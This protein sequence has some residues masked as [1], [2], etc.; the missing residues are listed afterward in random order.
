MLSVAEALAEIVRE[1]HPFQPE[2]IALSDAYGLTL[3]SP[4]VSDIDSPPFDKS[5]MD[6]FAV[7]AA[8]VV[9]GKAELQ[10]VEE[11]MAGQ[12]PTRTV[13][14][15]QATQ[16]MTGA[17]I[18]DGVDAVVRVEDSVYDPDTRIVRLATTAVQPGKNMITRGTNMHAGDEV[19]SAGRM[20]RPQELACLAELGCAQVSVRRRPRV[21]VLAT[22]DELVSVAE[23]PAAGQIRNSNETM[24]LAQIRRAGGEPIPLDIARD[25]RDDLRAKI[26][27]SLE[28]D[29]L[30]LSGGVSAGKL[31]LVPAVLEEAGVRQ[32]FHKV[33]VKPGKPLW[34]G[35]RK[36][37]ESQ[38]ANA[39][40]SGC[41]VFGLPGN[42]VSSMVC[43][44]LFVRTALRRLLGR[45]PAEPQMTQARLVEAHQSQSDRPTYYPAKLEFEA[46][47]VTVR[48]VNWHGSSD[49]RATVDA[50]GMAVVP[51]GEHQFEQG[52]T[53]E[54]IRWDED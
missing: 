22:G 13:A 14:A 38:A 18:P 6:G 21:A 9:D 8:D 23:T 46:D 7:R 5:L 41:Y 51:A 3:A 12:V 19:L 47:S 39:G 10:V 31:D 30:L 43:C 27:T 49:L 45:G 28:A 48:L 54:V 50:N 17:P 52:S 25:D 40:L 24:L 29:V 32:V 35:V 15:G 26:E 44:E 16:I 42:P 2:S 20:L 33:R 37:P 1:T 11:I 36:S 34:F 4:I 53:I